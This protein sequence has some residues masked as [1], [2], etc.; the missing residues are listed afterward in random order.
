M[1]LASGLAANVLG[2]FVRDWVTRE[3]V[4]SHGQYGASASL[5]GGVRTSDSAVV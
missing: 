5:R 1:S 2:G 3:E 4:D